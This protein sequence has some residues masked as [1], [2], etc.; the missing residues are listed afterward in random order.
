MQRVLLCVVYSEQLD[1]RHEELGI[2]SISALLRSKGYEVKLTGLTEHRIMK[3]VEQILEF[4]PTLIGF[5]VYTLSRDATYR[6]IQKMKTILPS[7]KISLGGYLPSYSGKQIL[8][9]APFVD[10]IIRGEGEYTFLKLTEALDSNGTL[11]DILGLTFRKEGE[12]VENPDAEL[13]KDMNELPFPS[14]DLLVDNKLKIAQVFS[15]RGCVRR[16][17]FCCSND[18]WKGKWRGKEVN[19]FV[20]EIENIVN[21]YHVSKFFVI[22]NSFEDP[23]YNT[24]RLEEI[25]RE[26]L[27]RN[28]KIS[29]H[30]NF[31]AELSRKISRELLE[32]LVQSGLCSILYGFEAANEQDLKCY[33]KFATIEDNRRAIEICEGLPITIQI[34]F[35]NF[36]PYSTFETLSKNVDFLEEYNYCTPYNLASKVMIFD[37]ASIKQ[38]LKDDGLFVQSAYDDPFCYKYKDSKVGVLSAFITRYMKMLDQNHNGPDRFYYYRVNHTN[39]IAHA[40]THFLH[41]KK[42]LEYSILEEHENKLNQLFLEFGHQNAK[43]FRELISLAQNG[44]DESKAESIMNQYLSLEYVKQLTSE[45]DSE[46]AEVYSRLTKI[47]STYDI[48]Y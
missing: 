48:F 43:W 2:C 14:R 35:I 37:G 42:K 20:D 41:D 15:S 24:K 29:Y 8:Q 4:K 17:S 25:A 31:R 13:I 27:R 30:C 28:L 36:N 16:C 5:P 9:E 40:K 10:Y 21:Q 34:G 7:V 26:I 6:V 22:D 47:D 45:I 39:M 32:L 11:D 33:H 19:R 12:I 23:G 38:S 3:E 1:E 46:M 18:F 44:W